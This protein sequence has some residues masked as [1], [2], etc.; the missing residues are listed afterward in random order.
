MK[1]WLAC[2]I[3]P[4]ALSAQTSSGIARHIQF[5]PTLPGTCNPAT[6][7]I[8]FTLAAGNGAAYFCSFLNTWS[9]MG[10][11]ASGITSLNTLSVP[12]Q[13]FGNDTN[14]TIT[15]AGSTHT[16]G[17]AGLLSP[18]RG[19]DG[20][21]NGTFTETRS[22]NV[23]FTGSFNPTFAIASSSTWS[24]PSGGG[25]LLISGGGLGTP[26]SGTAT[27]LTGLPL[28]TGVTGIL[29]IAN[30]GTN[31]SSAATALSNLGG[32]PLASPTFTGTVTIPALTLSGIT[33]SSQ[34]LQVNS[35]GVVAGTGSACGSGGGGV[36]FAGTV[37][38]SAIVT[39]ASSSTI[40]TPNASTTV[41]SSGN[42]VTPGGLT[43]G[44]GGSA[45]GA[46][47][48][49]QGTAPTT[50]TT[51]VTIFAPSSV[52]SYLLQLPAVA[53]TGIM[54][55]DNSSGT[56]TLSQA[57]LNGD[58]TSTTG[59]A[60]T[61]LKTNGVAF[62]A[63]ATT[64]APTGAI[65][66]AGQANTWT[67]GN[68]SFAAATIKL[69]SAGSFVATSTSMIGYD[70]TNTNVHVWDGADGIVAPVASAPTNGHCVQFSVSSGVVTI[71]DAGGACTT[72]GGGGT[73][74]SST[75]NYVAY[76]TSTGTVV[77]GEQFITMGQGGTNAALTAAV[78][79]LPYSTSSAI[80]LLAGNTAAS[81]MVLTSTGTGSAAQ[82]PTLKAAPA[83][84]GA[85]LLSTTIPGGSMVNNSI[86][87]SQLAGVQTRR[88][89][90][91]D[92]DSQSATALTAAQFSG[93][94]VIPAAA[95]I[96]EVDVTGG[97]QTLNG[98]AAAITVTGTSSIQIGKYTPNGGGTTN[99]LLS[100]ALATVSG[101]ACALTST[102]GTCINGN[103]SSSSVTV[104]TTSLAAGDIL[105]VTAATADAAQTWYNVA[106]I[107]TIN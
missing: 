79:S 35:S 102:S 49:G 90:I 71:A 55:G 4:A 100:A 18:A 68:Q 44:S 73:V 39:A 12:V 65:V 45:A 24:F 103:T 19:G 67:T 42:I 41:D 59:N 92:N 43:T 53:A 63:L 69:P 9:T 77:G 87:N 81:D 62:T 85:N 31:A 14:V 29:P 75:I 76:Y 1:K 78:G 105:S 23:T 2:L 36:S 51:A 70:S 13:T 25:T 48:L 94:C 93:H 104:S 30:G 37:T 20:V 34:C 64:A 8:Y 54:R 32:A 27:N 22:G 47:Q 28:T 58:C 83:I 82:A 57:E 89:C 17:W 46:M 38:V 96:V 99:S 84:S 74:S 66:G 33:G 86:G 52:T 72:G 6:G 106:I 15:S 5:G 91:I 95:T 80:A 3:L 98:T 107:Y 56:V 26:S 61:C 40:Q 16:L 88:T 50:G 101:K 10:S 60:V 11:T 21:N 7:D 97:T